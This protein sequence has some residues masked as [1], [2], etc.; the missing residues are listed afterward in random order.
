MEVPTVIEMPATSQTPLPPLPP[1]A[2][3]GLGSLFRLRDAKRRWPFAA[4]AAL[5]M[6]APVLLGLAAGNVA[7]G[8]VATI[9]AFTSLYG[10]DRPYLNRAGH[11]AIIALSFAVA[12]G[13][14]I[15]AASTPWLVVPTVALIAMAASF[16]CY[17]LRVGPPGA[18]MFALACAAGTAMPAQHL[19]PWQTALLVLA[20]GSFAWLFHMS[21]AL[22]WP[23]GPEKAAVAAAGHAVARF[24]EAAGTPQLDAARH[25]AAQA[26]FESWTTLVTHQPAQPRPDG[27][28]SRLRA[29]NRELHLR[30][31]EAM[32]ALG[33]GEPMPQSAA[34]QARRLAGQAGNPPR[35]EDRTDPNHIPLGHPGPLGSLREALRPWS[36]AMLVAA[37][38]GVATVVAGLVGAA[39][40]LERAY[41]TMAAA[42]LM[43]HQGLD[44]VRTLERGAQR[45]GG[46][47]VGLVLAGAILLMHPQGLWLAATLMLLQFL[48]EIFV[49]RNYAL[50]VVFITAAALTI[51]AGGQGVAD[52]GHLLELRG[53]D[54]TIGCAVG[55]AVFLLTV[56]RVVAVRVPSEIARTLECAATVVDCLAKGDVTTPQARVARRNLQ[57]AAIALLQ[58]YDASVGASP[59]H[60]EAAERL[61]P[62][63]V[64][65]QRLAYRVLSVCWTAERAGERAA[66]D[67]VA[68]LLGVD[69]NGQVRNALTALAAAAR[70][71]AGP[72]PI[73]QLPPFLAAEIATLSASLV[74]TP[75]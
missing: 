8:L 73:T 57:H 49:V 10:N 38:V 45:L 33:Q 20:G 43:L 63:L 75:A 74:H 12:V 70:S 64:A 71:G 6:G 35:G 29:L 62:A 9:G 16:L 59:R 15:W 18:Y 61:W 72:A 56:P 23:R 68:A 66:P 24:I 22:L 3:F 41:W 67:L 27:A 11:L 55:L 53:V 58:A 65:T 51:A 52:V 13:L 14:G 21:G 30:F 36:P 34:D 69:G 37:R 46:T 7:A 48:I 42:M 44:W 39:L 31:A 28:L 32:N 2:R 17:A 54:T 19:G 4:R 50:A 40:G 25:A 60:R 26:I 47:L 5:C 1:R